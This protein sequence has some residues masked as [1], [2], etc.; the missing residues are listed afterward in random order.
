MLSIL[1]FKNVLKFTFYPYKKCKI[2]LIFP[3]L[4]LCLKSVNIDL[5]A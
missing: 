3:N 2:I 4:L 1:Q 5:E